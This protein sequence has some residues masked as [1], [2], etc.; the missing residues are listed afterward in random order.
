LAR[1][2]KAAEPLPALRSY[3]MEI[4]AEAAR[5]GYAFDGRKI[6]GPRRAGR[7]TVKRGQLEYEWRRLRAKLKARDPRKYRGLRKVKRPSPHPLFRIVAGG[8]ED[9]ERVPAAKPGRK[10]RRNPAWK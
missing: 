7:I 4:R 5:R 10:G 8:V 1:F 6:R 9:W 3:L 2:R